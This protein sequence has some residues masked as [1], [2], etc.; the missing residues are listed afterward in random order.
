MEP[1]VR[2][3]LY[4]S[5]IAGSMIWSQE[6]QITDGKGALLCPSLDGS[7]FVDINLLFWDLAA[8]PYEF[9]S[10]TVV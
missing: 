4:F 7:W 1:V 2:K 10:T 5:H 3:V 8:S 6:W 9:R